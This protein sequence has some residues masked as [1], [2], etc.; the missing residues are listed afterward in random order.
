ML[1]GFGART[2]PATRVHDDLEVRALWLDDGSNRACLV[3]TDLLGMT[4]G[5]SGAVRAAIAAELGLDLAAVLTASTHTHNGPNA[6]EGGDALGWTTPEGYGELLVER[7]VPAARAAR[8]AA[9]PVT[10]HAV[11]AP[12]PDGL[13]VNR[14]GNPYEP[15]FAALDLRGADGSRA[16][17]LVNL[18]IHPVLFGAPWLEVGTDWVGPFREALQAAAG[19]TCVMLSGGL[20][21]VNPAERHEDI[22]TH[23]REAVAEAHALG[24]ALAAAVAQALA[25]ARPVEGGLATGAHTVT[26]RPA[27]TLLTELLGSAER[28]VE[29]VEWAIGDAHLVAVP[30]EPFHALA[31]RIDEA[32]GGVTLIAGLAPSWAGYLP[33][34]FGEGYEETVSL[35]RDAVA[36]IADAVVSGASR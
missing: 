1:A 24:A 3:V 14:R 6:M 15:W 29:L 2:E 18:S 35:G 23:L 27:G 16:G 36:A 30:G 32:R 31:R 17:T 12:L 8:D 25:D 20:G 21:D 9:E 10:L 5:F 4:E 7:C 13:S 26:V 19:G 33:E 34:P 22:P 11:R 28:T